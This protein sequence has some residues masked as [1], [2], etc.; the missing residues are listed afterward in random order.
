MSTEA[1]RSWEGG[2]DAYRAGPQADVLAASERINDA[3]REL[4][5]VRAAR[6]WT[7]SR[8]AFDRLDSANRAYEDALTRLPEH[9]ELKRGRSR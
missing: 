1:P 5:R 2:P 8:T 3:A 9:Q 6:D 7:A 4:N